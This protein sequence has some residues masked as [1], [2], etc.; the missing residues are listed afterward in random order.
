[1]TVKGDLEN[2]G[3]GLLDALSPTVN[4]LTKTI[5]R[6]VGGLIQSGSNT[7]EGVSKVGVHTI[8]GV[9]QAGVKTLNNLSNPV[10]LM[11][12]GAIALVI[13]IK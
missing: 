4:L 3:K 11:G 2:F 5:P 1:M 13:L 9:S 7:V 6:A 12:I 10:I 8:Q